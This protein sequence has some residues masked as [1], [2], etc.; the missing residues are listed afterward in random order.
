MVSLD[1][2]SEEKVVGLKEEE[3][4]DEE[5]DEW[6]DDEEEVQSGQVISNRISALRV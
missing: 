6:L 3:E 5:E 4:E 1:Q 2:D